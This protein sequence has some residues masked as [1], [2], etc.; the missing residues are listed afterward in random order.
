MKKL[1]TILQYNAFYLLLIIICLLYTFYKV[2]VIKYNSIYE[3]GPITLLG[4]VKTVKCYQDKISII[5]KNKELIKLD[6]Y[7]GNE[8][9]CNIEV[10]DTL[11]VTGEISMPKSNSI[12]NT[13]DY[14]KYLYNNHIYKLI[15]A[16]NIDVVKKSKNP[17]IVI[18]SIINKKVAINKYM[19]LFITGDKSLLESETYD[20]FK[21]S[22]VAHL[23]AISG[24]HITVFVHILRK[25]L[26]FLN[27]NTENVIIVLILLFYAYIA[28]FSPSVMR[29]FLCF[30]LDIINE[31]YHLNI[32]PFKV[33]FLSA[34][35]LLIVNPFIIYSTAFRYSYLT[36]MSI[37]LTS[38]YH[39]KNS[40]LNI[41]IITF[42]ATLFTLPLNINM[43]YEINLIVFISNLL[44]IPLV[45]SFIYPLSLIT[46]VFP[47]LL[48][49]Y[50][51]ST[52]I[53]ERVI[54]FI[55]KISFLNIL[56]P[57]MN[58]ILIIGYYII[59]LL[60]VTRKKKQYI[61]L[62][63]C[64]FLVNKAVPHFDK[65]T[66]V[67]FFDV[68]QGDSSLIVLPHRKRTVLIDTGGIVNFQGKNSYLV[69][70]NIIKYLKSI[71]IRKIDILVISHGDYD[72]MGDAIN[73]I[74]NYKV[75]RVI[76][77]CGPYNDLEQNLIKVLDMK[78]IKHYSC[79]KELY[80]DNN[81]LQFL[82]T[83]EYDN[84]N[85]NSNVIITELNG[86][87]FMLMGD[88]SVTTEKEIMSIYNLPDIDVLKVGHHGSKTS[89]SKEFINEINPKYSIISVGKNNRY[90][91][92]NKEV[93]DNLKDS[94][95]YR[96]D[97]DGSIM[98]KIKNNKLKIE[99][100]GS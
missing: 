100:C 77:N 1:K 70:D 10:G 96:T 30:Y 63:I 83:K 68:G 75:G 33:L 58:L 60:F 65:N 5:I 92:P 84:E 4:K 48:K 23:L 97:E 94:K 39:K 69:S 86:Y 50:V 22:G 82:Q 11:N 91:H 21:D 87:K 80:I 14:K 66:L 99:I 88:A 59:L 57:K 81:K 98:F 25:L 52:S 18:K 24:M 32:S 16:S 36:S 74:N 9:E 31:K 72:H 34:V 29:A 90:G 40:A 42:Y 6:Y 38:K 93:L 54:I 51:F 46:F 8:D 45:S 2:I 73:L 62:L 37:L 76:F 35:I 95:I 61:I 20:A 13:F 26:I 79:I 47:F 56:C 55:S 15:K 53:M 44:M 78:N 19:A 28:N 49:I 27:K 3:D 41:F 64:L 71:G 89:S 7:L 67:N 43:N 12:P 17:F 85:D